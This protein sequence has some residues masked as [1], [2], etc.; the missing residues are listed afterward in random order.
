MA[1]GFNSDKGKHDL[2]KDIEQLRDYVDKQDRKE[3]DTR[4]NADSA[5]YG[6]ISNLRTDMNSADSNLD[7]KIENLRERLNQEDS[8]LDNKIDILR[9]DATNKD[10]DL[11]DSINKLDDNINTMSTDIM[12]QVSSL[13]ATKE[14]AVSK[15]GDLLKIE[16]QFSIP[17]NGQNSVTLTDYDYENYFVISFM[18]GIV[19]TASLFG[20]MEMG[21]AIGYSTGTKYL[22]ITGNNPGQATA[23]YEYH[24]LL[25]HK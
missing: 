17:A 3:H 12:N 24:I 10:K 7:S 15:S 18:G 21:V 2:T 1:Y 11:E 25:M 14:D 4:A 16:G 5:I 19:G 22:L 6:T 13:Y 23:N 9:S 20:G 8:R